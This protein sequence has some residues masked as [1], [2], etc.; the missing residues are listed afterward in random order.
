MIRDE[1]G[2]DQSGRLG[3]AAFGTQQFVVVDIGFDEL[4]RTR[5]KGLAA[6]RNAPQHFARY[7]L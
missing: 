2:R 1:A 7:I 4:P 3:N 5:R 6:V